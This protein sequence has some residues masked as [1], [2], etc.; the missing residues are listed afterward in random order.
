MAHAHMI[1]HLKSENQVLA[2]DLGAD[3]LYFYKTNE[4]H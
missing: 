1:Q 2:T 3:K 4:N